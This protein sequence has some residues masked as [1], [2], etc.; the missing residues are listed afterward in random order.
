MN[1]DQPPPIYQ[2]IHLIAPMVRYLGFTYDHP[3]KI[4]PS[5][6]ELLGKPG[7]KLH[8]YCC[9]HLDPKTRD[10]TIYEIRPAMCRGY[11]YDSQCNYAKC[12]WKAKRARKQSPAEL[13]K[14]KRDLLEP[15]T[16]LEVKEP[17]K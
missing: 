2:D 9:K 6:D 13:R 16:K 14:R 3:P 1:G 17:S 10:C 5:D 4:N 11:P 15:A 12:T 7:T 8:Y